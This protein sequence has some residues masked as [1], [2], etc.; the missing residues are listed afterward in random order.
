MRVHILGIA[1]TFMGGVAQLA[2]AL[3]HQVSGSD[4]AVYP[5][6]SEQLA[7]AGIP[8]SDLDDLSFLDQAVDLVV[9][10][11][12]MTRGMLAVEA[13]LNR[14][15]AYCSGP[16]WLARYLLKDRWVLGVAGTHGK[17]TTSAM[18]AWILESAGL[19]PGFLIGGV[20]ENFG[21]SARLGSAPFFVVEADEYD[22]AFFDKRSKFVHYHPRTLVLNNLE[23]DHADIFSD[24]AAIQTQ[25]HHLIRTVPSN[26]LV[27]MPANE[28]ALETVLDRGCWTPVYRHN[29]E[30]GAPQSDWH[31]VLL[32]P[33]A[34]EFEVW[35]KQSLQGVVRWSLTGD[36]NVRNAMS[37]IMA[38]QHA[39][40]P[41]AQAIDAMARFKGVKRRM[42]HLAS[43]ADI[44]LYDDFA[45][46]PT[47]IATTLAGQ[48]ARISLSMEPRRLIAV[49]EPR[50]NTMR[51]GVFSEQLVS[52]FDAADKVM[53]YIDPKWGWQ[54][55]ESAVLKHQI[56]IFSSYEAL[57]EGLITQLKKGDDVVFMS[58]GS[59]AGLPAKVTKGL[60]QTMKELG[61]VH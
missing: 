13:T 53:L 28:P 47:A 45:H 15:Q 48:K 30:P 36:H 51:M 42:T 29:S 26:G 58:N 8:I 50:S 5:P 19:A 35:F 52:A 14:H 25:F 44:N 40:V 33:D 49:C 3:G 12:A 24:L 27:V 9:I 23:F 1:G 32:K 46:H 2:Q 31:S 11:N 6:M 16:E 55:P 34:S 54:L 60:K 41:V 18:L 61:V 10:G 21:Q 17:T 39:G 59:F 20:P 56:E 38:A 57:Y 7:E 22:T 43:L 37:A 4:K